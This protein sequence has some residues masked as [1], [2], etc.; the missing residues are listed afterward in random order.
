MNDRTL[1]WPTFY[2]VGA[3]KCG[4]TSLWAHLKKHPQVFL[5]EL[6]EPHY[7]LGPQPPLQDGDEVVLDHCAGYLERYQSLYRP[8][9][10]YPAIGDASPSYLWEETSAR[11]IYA[12]CP[13]ARIIISLRDP[14]M[15]AHSRYLMN[16]TE[17]GTESLPFHE[18]LLKDRERARKGWWTS[19]LYVEC[20]LYYAQ[21]RRYL[22][23]FG[24]EQV[25]V[26]LFDELAKSPEA[27]YLKVTRHIGIGPLQADA[28]DLSLARN[29]Y[30]KARLPSVQGFVRKVTTEKLRQKLA[31]AP[32]RQLLDPLRFERKKPEIDEESR[33]YLQQI[34]E[35]DI[36]QLEDLLGRKLPE[37]RKSWI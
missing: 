5:P 15:R 35:P 36:A 19:R 1:I 25:L 4:T 12:A 14:V 22:E 37:L 7:F 27:F 26:I 21:V 16:V 11:S 3:V 24:R 6:K 2:I 13:K 10:G 9:D 33:R 17:L 18:A 8:A 30:R 34:F 31:P 29:Q 23:T 28:T 32:L 20:G